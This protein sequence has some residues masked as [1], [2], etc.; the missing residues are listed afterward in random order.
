MGKG[1]SQVQGFYYTETFG[2]VAKMDY[3]RLVLAIVASKYWEVHHMYAKSDLIHGGIEKYMYMHHPEAYTQDPSLVCR[4][5]K[6][7]Y[8]IKQT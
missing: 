3:V 1:F 8:G 5:K 4:L 7:L 2:P 6:S